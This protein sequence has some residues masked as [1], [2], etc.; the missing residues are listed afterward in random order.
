MVATEKI[1]LMTTEQAASFLHCSVD[2][3]LRRIQ[4]NGLPA[5]RARGG[6]GVPWRLGRVDGR[7][8][9]VDELRKVVG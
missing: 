2:T 8:A 7:W 5:Y 3:I 4:C 1:E 9:T 6:K